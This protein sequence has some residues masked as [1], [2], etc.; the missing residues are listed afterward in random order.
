MCF[1]PDKAA[2]QA[3]AQQQQAAQ[4][5]KRREIEERSRQKREDIS[6]AV[7]GRTASSGRSGGTGRRSLFSS[8]TGAGGFIGRFN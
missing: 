2:R 6:E 4:E 5:Q 3:A 7:E 1:G 8:P